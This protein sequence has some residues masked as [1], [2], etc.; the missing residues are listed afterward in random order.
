MSNNVLSI[1]TINKNNA[2]GLKHT[3][4]NLEKLGPGKWEHVIIDACSDDGSIEVILKY[5]QR[6]PELKIVH[7]SETDEGIWDAMNKG[8]NLAKGSYLL[9]LNSGDEIDLNADFS[10]F[11]QNLQNSKSMWLFGNAIRINAKTRKE[12]AFFNKKK[13][14]FLKFV[15]GADW[16]PHGSS[17]ILAKKFRELGGYQ[18]W[19]LMADQ[20]LFMKLWQLEPPTFLDYITVRFES[21]GIHESLSPLERFKLWG[22]ARKMAYRYGQVRPKRFS[23]WIVFLVQ[24]LKAIKSSISRNLKKKKFIKCI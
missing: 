13:V 2:C 14:E 5:I 12:E 15:Y 23:G 6:N 18:E 17:L 24:F 19:S 16:I 21:G 3:L 10:D 20:G 8:A 4:M 22:A 1:V 9:F 11:L 7:V